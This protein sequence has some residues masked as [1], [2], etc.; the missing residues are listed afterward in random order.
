[1]CIYKFYM[2]VLCNNYCSQQHKGT[3][4]KTFAM[5][6]LENSMKVGEYKILLK[7]KRKLA[8][9]C[10][11]MTMLVEGAILET[12]KSVLNKNK[13]DNMY[14]PAWGCHCPCIYM[15]AHHEMFA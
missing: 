13:Y 5:T 14:T 9:S 2:T 3:N 8:C 10:I 11:F 12:G 7:K 4:H 15:P 1:M 6:I